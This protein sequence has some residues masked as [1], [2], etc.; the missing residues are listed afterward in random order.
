MK[1]SIA[2]ILA[3]ISSTAAFAPA[4]TAQFSMA[5]RMSETPEEPVAVDENA[6][7]EGSEEVVGEEAV[8]EPVEEGK[9]KKK[10]PAKWG[11]VG[12]GTTKGVGRK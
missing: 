2:L 6:P 8:E 11:S 9:P 3:A 1:L 12:R 7:V 4:S 10:R 5:S